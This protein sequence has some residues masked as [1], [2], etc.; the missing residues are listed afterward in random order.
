MALADDI[1]RRS[2]KATLATFE[3]EVVV[4]PRNLAKVKAALRSRGKRIIGT[5]EEKDR[6]WFVSRAAGLL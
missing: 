5:S 2:S 3:R 1:I 4:K 6:V